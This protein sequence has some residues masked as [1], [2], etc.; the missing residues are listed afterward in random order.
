[1]A[2]FYPDAPGLRMAYERDGTTGLFLNTKTGVILQTLTAPQMAEMNDEDTAYPALNPDDNSWCGLCFIFPELRDI[3][4][5][6]G[7]VDYGSGSEQGC[8]WSADTTNGIDGTWTY[9]GATGFQVTFNLPGLR[10]I[11]AVSIT[12]ARAVRWMRIFGGSNTRYNVRSMQ[13][14]G[15]PSSGQNP[16]RL[17]LWHPTLDQE[18][19]GAHFDWGDIRPS[20]S[21]DKE[22]RIKNNS[23]SL[24]ANTITVSLDAPTD[25]TPSV[26]AQH[27]MAK[28]SA[29]G[30]FGAT[31]TFTSLAPGAMSEIITLRRVSPVNAV[32]NLWWA[33]ILASAATFTP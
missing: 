17:R 2:G 15:R 10:T 4:G 32:M 1:M 8:Y 3:V 19:G 14:F 20:S 27:T 6:R 26:P 13:V 28:A 31:V 22:F 18:V 25:T 9:A 12:G 21:A 11:N 7:D 5:H 24:T 30:T 29:P 23:G 33:R 16:D